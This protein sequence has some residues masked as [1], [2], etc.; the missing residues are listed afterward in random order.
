VAFDWIKMRIGLA[1]DPA[2]IGIAAATGLDEFAVVGRLH[3]V[4]SWADRHTVDG[5]APRVTVSWLNRYISAD[6]FGEAM[7]AAGWLESNDGGIRFPNFDRHN[8]QTGKQRALTANRVSRHRDK[9]NGNRNADS[10]GV[11]VTK[12]A[13]TQHNTKEELNTS[14][15]RIADRPMEGVERI[16]VDDAYWQRLRESFIAGAEIANH[17]SRRGLDQRDRETVIRCALVADRFLP[18]GEL[19]GILSR[20]K[21]AIR[22]DV[23]KS[24]PAYFRGAFI[25]A[26]ESHTPPIDFHRA[27]A[28]FE[29]PIEKLSPGTPA[30]KVE[31]D[32]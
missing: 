1:D 21:E 3:A 28:S 8:T 13:P 32:R 19:D 22:R 25:K 15:D 17:G 12:S 10:N 30:A 7:T 26:C 11:S 16:A 23:P 18:I 27:A 6:G 2:V 24:P 5:N 31:E 29:I 9:S 14:I 20:L 4:W